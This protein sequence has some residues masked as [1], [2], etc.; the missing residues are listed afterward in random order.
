M[1]INKK[2]FKPTVKFFI[3]FLAVALASYL[4][5]KDTLKESFTNTTYIVVGMKF[6]G[7]LSSIYD[8]FTNTDPTKDL[9]VVNEKLP[10]E[11]FNGSTMTA[12]FFKDPKEFFAYYVD[13]YPDIKYSI[14]DTSTDKVIYDP[15]AEYKT[16]KTM[17]PFPNT[18]TVGTYIVYFNIFKVLPRSETNISSSVASLCSPIA[19]SIKLLNTYKKLLVWRDEEYIEMR[20]P[21]VRNGSVKNAKHEIIVATTPVLQNDPI[22][23][24]SPIFG[25]LLL[26]AAIKNI[27]FISF[28]YE[29]CETNG[30]Q[31]I[32]GFA[33]AYNKL[34]DSNGN[35]I[36]S[37][38]IVSDKPVTKS[39][40]KSAE[41]SSNYT[42]PIIIGSVLVLGGGAIYLMMGRSSTNS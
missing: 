1:K 6:E 7:A 31:N 24:M 28:A 26:V 17:S 3:V 8:F 34:Y 37:G 30:F 18:K 13:K 29:E 4:L 33:G 41:S 5:F 12:N 35:V 38:A 32:E 39:A 9:P 25:I 42:I 40:T 16:N 21:E 11:S 22:F 15:I 27:N 14:I 23:K 10:G 20:K 2:G 19:D 36:S